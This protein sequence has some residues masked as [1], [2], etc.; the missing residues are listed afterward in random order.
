MSVNSRHW[1]SIFKRHLLLHTGMYGLPGE[2]TLHVLTAAVGRGTGGT[3]VER[4]I[5]IWYIVLDALVSLYCFVV[6]CQT[7]KEYLI[8]WQRF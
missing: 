8:S 4:H 7:G 5:V 2:N 1:E 6:N 3:T